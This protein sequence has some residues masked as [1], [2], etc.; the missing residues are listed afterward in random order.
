MEVRTQLLPLSPTPHIPP[1][2]LSS[3]TDGRDGHGT[4]AIA[5]LQS[6]FSLTLQFGVS[7]PPVFAHLANVEQIGHY[8]PKGLSQQAA[9]RR[10]R[11]KE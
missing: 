6:A 2:L 3:Y 1:H 9:K 4:L 10:Q 5:N 7:R 11:A 8:Q